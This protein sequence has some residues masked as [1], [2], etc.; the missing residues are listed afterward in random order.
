MYQPPLDVYCFR[1]YPMTMSRVRSLFPTTV[2]SSWRS[3]QTM[4]GVFADAHFTIADQSA[5][6]GGHKFRGALHG[7]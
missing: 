2:G 5:P 7:R 6:R 4:K 1:R 3:R